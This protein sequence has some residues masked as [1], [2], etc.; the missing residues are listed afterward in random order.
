MRSRDEYPTVDGKELVDLEQKNVEL[1]V[2]EMLQQLE[3]DDLRERHWPLEI[4]EVALKIVGSLPMEFGLTQF[5]CF[6]D[7]VLAEIDAHEHPQSV[8]P[9]EPACG[10]AVMT[11]NV[12]HCG[13]REL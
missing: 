6:G 8:L 2:C 11:T 4:L 9:Q 5:L 7:C 1:V 13:K 3:A 10:E 12:K